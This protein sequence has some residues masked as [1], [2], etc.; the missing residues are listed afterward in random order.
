MV[1]PAPSWFPRVPTSTTPDVEPRLPEALERL[2]RNQRLSVVL[3]YAMEWT[4]EE[5]AR[6]I[7]RSR[8][9]V[10]THLEHG[11]ARLREELEVTID[12]KMRQCGNLLSRAGS[13]WMRNPSGSPKTKTGL[14][15]NPSPKV[16]PSMN[17]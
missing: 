14:L 1:P 4:E 16:P 10:R 13:P 7:G 3:V 2:T 8:S 5:A 12:A 17:F 11:L 6:P 15:T 9:T